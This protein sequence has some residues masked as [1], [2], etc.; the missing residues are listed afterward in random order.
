MHRDLTLTKVSAAYMLW[1]LNQEKFWAVCAGLS[2][3]RFSQS[4]GWAAKLLQAY[5]FRRARSVRLIVTG[6][7]FILSRFFLDIGINPS[8]QS[9]DFSRV[10]SLKKRKARL[11]AVL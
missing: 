8:V 9:T 10:F 11:K 7:S 2:A 3:I 1:T 5:L 6:S 4:S